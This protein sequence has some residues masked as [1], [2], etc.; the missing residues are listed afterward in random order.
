[1]LEIVNFI[2]ANYLTFFNFF[3]LWSVSNLDYFLCLIYGFF[4]V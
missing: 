1:M 2:K 4:I 3:S